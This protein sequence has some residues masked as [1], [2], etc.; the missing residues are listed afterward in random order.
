[1]NEIN[2]Q[3][4]LSE[5]VKNH[6][7]KFDYA[8]FDNLTLGEAWF[9]SRLLADELLFMALYRSNRLPIGLSDWRAI[10]KELKPATLLQAAEKLCALCPEYQLIGVLADTILETAIITSE[11]RNRLTDKPIGRDLVLVD[12]GRKDID[13]LRKLLKVDKITS[14]RPSKYDGNDI[15]QDVS[16]KTFQRYRQQG[17]DALRQYGEHIRPI[18]PPQIALTSHRARVLEQVRT[19]SML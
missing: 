12:Q 16:A 3:S 19:T 14:Y 4:Y 17:Q 8:E 9:S 18:S 15:Q 6:Q 11:L 5:V 1:M 13:A 7:P 10:R 2:C